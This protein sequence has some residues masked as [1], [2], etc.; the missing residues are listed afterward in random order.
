MSF[1]VE[2][3]LREVRAEIARLTLLEKQL[4]AAAGDDS[5]ESSKGRLSPKGRSVISIS[6]KLRHARKA[7]DKGRVRQLEREL[8]EAKAK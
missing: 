8:K 3:T 1:S 4:V 6:A 5:P 2:A 7:G